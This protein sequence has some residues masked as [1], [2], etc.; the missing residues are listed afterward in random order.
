MG[1]DIQYV[2]SSPSPG[3]VSKCF[4]ADF[5]AKVK[6]VFACVRFPENTL[7]ALR[8]AAESQTGSAHFLISLSQLGA[9]LSPLFKP[10]T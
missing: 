1:P 4:C 3:V 6:I 2:T 8:G 5:P 9:F 7:P 10:F